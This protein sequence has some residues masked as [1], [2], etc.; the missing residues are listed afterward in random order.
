MRPRGLFLSDGS[1]HSLPSA[2]DYDVIGGRGGGHLKVEVVLTNSQ[3]VEQLRNDL[4]DREEDITELKE[5][6]RQAEYGY[7][8]EVE[9]NNRISTELDELWD[10]VEAHGLKKRPPGR[11]KKKRR[12]S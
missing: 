4:A 11:G 7:M 3:L 12:T 6:L 8:C 10:I 2:S 1:F 5:H 9:V